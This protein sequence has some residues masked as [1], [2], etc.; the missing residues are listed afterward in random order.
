MPAATAR[1]RCRTAC[2]ACSRP[3]RAAKLCRSGSLNSSAT[4]CCRNLRLLS[5]LR[6]LKEKGARVAGIS[7][8]VARL[9][10][11][12]LRRPRRGHHRLCLRNSGLA[13]NRQMH[14]GHRHPVVDEGKLFEDQPDA[15]VI[16]SWHIADELAP[17]AQGQGLPRPID[18]AAAG[19]A[20]SLERDTV[21]R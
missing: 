1:T 2:A 9:D 7:A 21:T 17:Q 15:A 4:S 16:F 3:S 18:H 14:A 12:Q 19:A 5:M 20:V 11:G 13:E 8:P 10:A 6:D